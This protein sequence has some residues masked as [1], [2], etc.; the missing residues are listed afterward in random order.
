MNPRRKKRLLA[1]SGTVFSLAIALALVLYA[2][3]Q[4]IDLFYTPDE[5]LNGKA[6]TGAPPTIGQHLQV[7]GMVVLHSVRHHP[8]SL[9]VEF[10]L[11]DAKS[12]ISVSYDQVLP[13]LFGEGQ[14]VVARGILDKPDHVT[15]TQVL[16]KHDENYIPPDVAAAMKKNHQAANVA[17]KEQP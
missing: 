13:D 4:N 3:R 12:T 5:I 1:V 15:A 11:T 2:L 10:K 16:A 9:D 14:A 7:G 17:T 6:E 8:H